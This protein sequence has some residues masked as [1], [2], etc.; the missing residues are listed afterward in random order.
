MFT[1][2]IIDFKGL[3]GFTFFSVLK[4]IYFNFILQIFFSMRLFQCYIH[5]SEVFEFTRFNI[6][7][8]LNSPY[9]IELFDNKNR[10]RFSFFYIYIF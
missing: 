10:L 6:Y 7:F 4:L 8:F 3:H 5:D 9:K 1:I 2:R